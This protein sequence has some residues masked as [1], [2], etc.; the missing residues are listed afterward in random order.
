MGEFTITV[1]EN[2]LAVALTSIM[3]MEGKLDDD[4]YLVVNGISINE[5]G[6]LEVTVEAF[7]ETIN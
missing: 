7:G 6:Y 4:S 3:Q 5:D 1:D 2:F